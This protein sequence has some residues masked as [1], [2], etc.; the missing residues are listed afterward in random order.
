MRTELTPEERVNLDA[1][2]SAEA[3][4]EYDRVGLTGVEKAL[5]ERYF[6]ETGRVLDIGCALGRTTGPLQG[7]GFDVVGIDVS[8]PMIEQARLR[9]PGLDFRVGNACDLDFSDRSFDYVLFSF[10]G[11]DLIHPE[12]RRTRALREINRVLK[13]GGIF[14]FSS[15]NSWQLVSKDVF[16]Y[17]WLLRFIVVNIA[18]RKILSKYKIDKTNFGENITHFINPPEQR[19]QLTRAGFQLLEITGSFKGALKYVEPWPHYVARKKKRR[20]KKG[21][22]GSSLTE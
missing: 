1:Y 16:F 11:I 7:L 13:D 21:T 10:N 9:F 3:L 19:R 5:V 20:E 17:S 4:R 12:E 15:H 8:S 22:E 18:R 2:S 14:V 6:R